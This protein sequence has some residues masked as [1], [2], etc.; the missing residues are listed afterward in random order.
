MD[1]ASI[2]PHYYYKFCNTARSA[3]WGLWTIMKR[4]ETETEIPSLADAEQAKWRG[5]KEE[6]DQAP[7]NVFTGDRALLTVQHSPIQLHL[8]AS[9]MRHSFRLESRMSGCW[10]KQ[11]HT[12][13]YTHSLPSKYQCITCPGAHWQSCHSTRRWMLLLGQ[14]SFIDSFVLLI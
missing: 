12:H 5:R 1:I 14:T 2:S 7:R 10:T 9:F 11:T 8:T 3:R 13:T 4:V 6:C